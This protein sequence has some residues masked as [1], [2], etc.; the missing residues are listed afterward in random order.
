MTE[1]RSLW[2]QAPGQ[3]LFSRE[4]LP[5]LKKGWCE[6]QTLF[7][8]VSP[9]TERLVLTGKIPLSQYKEMKCP[10]MGG[11]FSFP[12]KYG[13]SVV[14]IIKKGP[15]K[16]IGERIHVIHPHQDRCVVRTQD[17]YPL[18]S[19]IPSQRAVLASNLETAVNAMWD[20]EIRL[21]EKVLVVGFGSIGSLIA[22][23]VQD[24]FG[25]DVKVVDTLPDKRKMAQSMG[26][27]VV[28]PH[29][30]STLFDLAFHTSGTSQ[31][32]QTSI[33]SVSQEGRVIELSWYGTQK[34]H[35][36]LGESFHK[37]RKKIISSQVSRIPA[38]LQSRWDLRRRKKLVFDLLEDSVFDSHITHRIPFLELPRLFQKFKNHSSKGV[39]YLI[40]YT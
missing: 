27:D 6:I 40:E 14:G 25:T 17:T 28:Y 8:A 33:N 11:D 20:S 24:N 31:G 26:F 10:Y 36:S 19:H 3:P 16:R 34:V 15:R 21:G 29:K 4:H 22:R 30:N 2:F 37:G 12:I 35:L 13:Y 5:S 32:L 23:L 38:E 18:P 9:G 7:S 1:A 39:G